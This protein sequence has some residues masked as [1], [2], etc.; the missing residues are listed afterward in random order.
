MSYIAEWY[1]E[2]NGSQQESVKRI[3]DAIDA[4]EEIEL[5]EVSIEE[6]ESSS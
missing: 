4:G 2:M 6:D 1:K 5:D 3:L